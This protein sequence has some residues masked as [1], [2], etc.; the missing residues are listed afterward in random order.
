MNIET[1]SLPG[2]SAGT[3]RQLVCH[4]WGAAGATPKIY[5]QA[6]LHA[7]EMPGVLVLQHLMDLLDAAGDRIAGQILVVPMANPIGL[8]QWIAHK[9]QGRQDLES[10]QNFNRHYPDLA[11]LAGDDLDQRLTTSEADNLAIVRA[12]FGKALDRAVAKS[13]LDA[14]R[15]ALLRWSHDADYVLDLHCDHEAVMHLYASPS[16]PDDTHLLCRSVGAEIAL[17]AEVSGGHAFDEAHTAPWAALKRRY[18]GKFPIP[19]GCFSTTLEYRGQFD[20]DAGLAAKDAEN[21]MTFLTA[22][23]AI[24]SK[25]TPEFPDPPHYPL[26]GSVEVFAPQGGVVSWLARPGDR[27]KK[28]QVLAH[29]ID[30]MT[31]Q[32]MDVAAPIEGL[33]FRI[34]LWRSC[35]RGQGLCHVAGATEIRQGDL[36]SD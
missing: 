27:V 34:E 9:P 29:V 21:L 16:R 35:L 17:I 5:L 25:A 19:A 32:R 31:R 4:V 26:A 36:L 8:S 10:L 18:D 22:I 6:G 14:Q 24:R 7:D 33:M 11:A 20:V 3:A 23:G 30:P 13:D 2:D 12:A 1:V 28:D 15:L